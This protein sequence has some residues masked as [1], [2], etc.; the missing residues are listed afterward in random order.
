MF[1]QYTGNEYTS[2]RLKEGGEKI[3]VVAGEIVE[4]NLPEL[5]FTSNWFKK[6][7]VE[8]KVIDD[9]KPEITLKIK[10]KK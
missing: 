2:I 8:T 10:K 4:S 9:W 6:V 5:Y 1:Y 3:K 7:N